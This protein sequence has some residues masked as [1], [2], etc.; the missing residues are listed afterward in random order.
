M[1]AMAVG[2]IKK[3]A[4][5]EKTPAKLTQIIVKTPFKVKV[6][7]P[8]FAK[9]LAEALK[10]NGVNAEAEQEVTR[11]PPVAGIASAYFATFPV[12]PLPVE[13]VADER[14]TLFTP[15]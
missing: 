1:V 13:R 9:A 11:K 6:S 7:D 15:P 3:A 14:A 2:A 8:K 12:N 5:P 4:H 10:K